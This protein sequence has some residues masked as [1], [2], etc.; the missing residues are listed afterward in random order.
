[1]TEKEFKLCCT[2][3]CKAFEGRKY[4]EIVKVCHEEDFDTII[5]MNFTYD[6]DGDVYFNDSLVMYYKNKL[7]GI[8]INCGDNYEI[9]SVK[10]FL[11]YFKIPFK[12]IV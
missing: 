12:D 10:N 6:I 3:F 7:Y 8:C 5:S 9:K 2:L 1:M 4:G 11:N